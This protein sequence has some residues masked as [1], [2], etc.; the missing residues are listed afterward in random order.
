MNLYYLYKLKNLITNQIYIGYTNNPK[1]RESE[2][3]TLRCKEQ[4]LVYKSIKHYGWENHCFEVFCTCVKE[5]YC[6]LEVY[7][8]NHYNSY[9]YDNKLGLN[10]TK[11]GDNPPRM[12][13]KLN[14][15]YGKTHTLES[16]N[17]ISNSK[18]G[19]PSYNKGV[20]LTGDLLLK[21]RKINE[22]KR[23]KVIQLDKNGNFIKI[24]NGIKL[25]SRELKISDATIIAVC[26]NNPK[27][28]TAGGFKW[29][30]LI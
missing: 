7:F 17:K 4:Q 11:G 26:K 3:R 22:L 29:K 12:P 8:I 16:R 25:A 10:L 1:R 19:K 9:Y 15:M 13:G 20:K 23:K 18:K 21:Q 2:Y 5:L 24:W 28:H 14:P 27:N 30:Y 6:N